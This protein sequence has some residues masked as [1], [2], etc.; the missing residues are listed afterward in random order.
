MVAD[1]AFRRLS[2]LP[3]P[4]AAVDVDS[5]S[6]TGTRHARAELLSLTRTGTTVRAVLAWD[7]PAAGDPLSPR[8]LMGDA[9]DGG[10]GVGWELFDVAAGTVAAPLRTATGCLCSSNLGSLVSDQAVYWADF[11]AP[12][13]PTA[14]LL[15]GAGLPALAGLTITDGP[16]AL[17]AGPLVDWSGST[18]P[19]TPGEGALPAQLRTVRRLTEAASGETDA[20]SGTRR[21]VGVPSD[22]LFALDSDRLGAT[23]TAAVARLGAFLVRAARGQKVRVVGHTDDQGTQAYN[24]D[25]SRRRAQAVARALTPTV[26]AAGITLEVVGRGESQPLLPNRTAGGD[27]IPANQARNRRVAVEFTAA[28]GSAAGPG[29]SGRPASTVPAAA[30]APG[31]APAGSLASAGLTVRNGVIRADVMQAQRVAGELVALQVRFVAAGT[32]PVESGRQRAGARAEPLP[33]RHQRDPGRRHPARPRHRNGL[34]PARRGRRLLPV[35]PRPR[36][37]VGVSR[38]AVHALGILP[39]APG[40]GHLRRPRARQVRAGARGPAVL[41]RPAGWAWA[42]H[43]LG[44]AWVPGPMTRQRRSS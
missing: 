42:G 18:P 1:G 11:P 21:E 39:R 26:A 4:L 30:P 40:R 25:L 23:G 24:L 12:S 44:P 19:A 33:L 17:P 38:P 20:T 3:A 37:R 22:V 28:G 2:T 15:L 7:R 34:P 14:T 41:N 36:R 35:H 29:T 5:P 32:T 10:Q 31:A 13:G 8:R 43:R 9:R 16:A 6:S 27:P